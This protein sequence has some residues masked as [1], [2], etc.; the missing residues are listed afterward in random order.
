MPLEIR[1]VIH[2]LWLKHTPSQTI[3][4]EL[5]EI[6]SK[7][8]ISLRA[9][10]KWTAASHGERTQLV[11]LPRFWRPRDTGKIDAVHGLIECERH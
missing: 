7:D 1:A 3:S 11:D 10:E 9:V 8:V 6:H 5:E 2:S 4:S